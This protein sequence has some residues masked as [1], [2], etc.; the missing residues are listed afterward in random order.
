MRQKDLSVRFCE[1]GQL[2]WL[3]GLGEGIGKKFEVKEWKVFY[4]KKLFG[5]RDGKRV[6]FAGP[7]PRQISTYICKL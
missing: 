5:F 7:Q 6:T 1:K 2:G 3:Y 4:S